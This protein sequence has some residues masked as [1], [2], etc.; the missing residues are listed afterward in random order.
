MPL[1]IVV[2]GAG[3]AGMWAAIAARR[4]ISLQAK[5]D[6]IEVVVIAPE[7]KLVLRPRLYEASP[8]DM[9]VP[10]GD[11]FHATGVR[12]IKGVVDIIRDDM[13]E[14]RLVDSAGI[15]STISYDR[16]ILAAGSCLVRYDIPGLD[17]FAF[18]V[19]QLNEATQLDLHLRDLAFQPASFARNTVVI[20]GGGFTGIEVATSLP[21]R[22]RSILRD[23]TA[24]VIL[25]DAGSEVAST[26]GVGLRPIIS[27]VLH[28]LG[29]E[30][31][32]GTTVTSVDSG[33]VVTSS[34]ER[35]ETLT[36]IWTAGM[37]ATP[38]TEQV[39]GKRDKIGRLHVDCNLRVPSVKNVFATGDAAYAATDNDGHYAM[40]SCQHAI[41]LGRIAGHNA[42]ADLLNLEFIP[43]TQ[44]AYGALLDLGPRRAV[45][46]NGWDRKVA[47]T[48]ELAKALKQYTNE[49][50][51]YPPKADREKA[52]AAADPAV[53][54]RYLS[55]LWGVFLFWFKSKWTQLI[56]W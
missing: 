5:D 43:Y 11:L 25:I 48:G 14:V 36:A 28:D 21:M 6:S 37:A 31:R 30:V 27:K 19:D 7:E 38:L 35:I 54:M 47:L 53:R 49:V 44:R 9:I 8:A 18:S 12:F 33:A 32:L 42:A 22:M 40:Q 15:R 55:N 51:I 1:R 10:L 26:L 39:E 56:S 52:F 23:G 46:A 2:V 17:K 16:L 45:L 29:V 20:C 13:Q 4:L 3:F 41:P 34:G 50:L 24:R